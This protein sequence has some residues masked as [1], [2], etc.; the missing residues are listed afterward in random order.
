MNPHRPKP[1][2]MHYAAICVPPQPA[3]G[4]GDAEPADFVA[5]GEPDLMTRAALEVATE[6]LRKLA[7]ELERIDRAD[8]CCAA[9]TIRAV[10]RTLIIA[11]ARPEPKK[12]RRA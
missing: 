4:K 5:R 9:G 12:G 1:E 2:T 11:G 8:T 6:T 3:K 7:D 10:L